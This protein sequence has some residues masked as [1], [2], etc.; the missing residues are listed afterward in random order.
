MFWVCSADHHIDKIV[1]S[2]NTQANAS[3]SSRLSDLD[4][5]ASVSTSTMTSGLI[6]PATL[7]LPPGLLGVNGPLADMLSRSQKALEESGGNSSGI[8]DAVTL[9]KMVPAFGTKYLLGLLVLVKNTTNKGSPCDL[10]MVE[11]NN[12]IIRIELI[13]KVTRLTST[14]P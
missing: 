11:Q 7:S 10:S 6:K 5:A 3:S 12:L 14:L 1:S 8:L 2:Q 4:E 13:A 9:E